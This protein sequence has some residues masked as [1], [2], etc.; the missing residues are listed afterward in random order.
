MVMITLVEQEYAGL[1]SLM[2]DAFHWASPARDEA[3]LKLP[4]IAPRAKRRW[5]RR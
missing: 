4:G 1:M 5:P 3:T 2:A